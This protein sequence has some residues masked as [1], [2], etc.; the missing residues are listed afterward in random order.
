MQITEEYGCLHTPIVDTGVAQTRVDLRLGWQSPGGHYGIA[1]LVNN[2]LDKQ[3]LTLA[4]NGGLG[5]FTLGTPY[6]TATAPRFIGV[7]MQAQL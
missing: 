3:Y 4:P 1:L 6:A 7:E 2:A 5:A